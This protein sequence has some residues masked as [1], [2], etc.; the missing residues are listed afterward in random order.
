MNWSDEWKLSSVAKT[1]DVQNHLWCSEGFLKAADLAMLSAA[2]LTRFQESYSTNGA[3][4]GGSIWKGM[5]L[6]S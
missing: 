3:L 1:L 2:F 4:D 5:V 6:M